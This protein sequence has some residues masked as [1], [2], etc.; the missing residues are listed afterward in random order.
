MSEEINST[1]AFME[2][3]SRK[4]E[5][6]DRKI[7]GIEEKIKLLPDNKEVIGGLTKTLEGLRDDV[8]SN[9]FPA[10]K[11]RELL[12][13]LD[14]TCTLLKQQLKNKVL[15]EHHVPKLIWL[16]AGL[17]IVFALVCSGWYVTYNN[18]DSCIANDTKYRS[19]KL[20][21]TQKSLQLYLDRID[22]IIK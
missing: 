8:K 13:S 20:D 11:I 17:F 5:G 3:T 10:E 18:L 7:S 21:T 22:W 4:V 1:N 2:V 14:F 16:T 6:L 9:R 19:M 15:H 12:D